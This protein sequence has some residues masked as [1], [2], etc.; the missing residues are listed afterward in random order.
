V[1]ERERER[2]RK[3]ELILTEKSSMYVCLIK[4]VTCRDNGFERKCSVNYERV[5]S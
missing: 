4:I 3:R 5:E 1:R 2:E